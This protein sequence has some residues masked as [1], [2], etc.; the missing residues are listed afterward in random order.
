[1]K[2]A[3]FDCDGTLV[4]SAALIHETMRRTFEKFG[5]PEP[6]FEDTK[7]IIGLSLDI[8]IARM[9]G[10]P[11]VEQ[12]DIEMT[13]HYKSLFS[14]VRQDLDYKEPLF[15]GIREMI[16]AICG[17]EDLLVGAV[18]G[19]SRRGLDLVM[20]THGFDRH[21][22]V[23]RTA[24]DCPSKPHP[25]MVTECCD[26]TGMN[27]RDAIVIGDAIYDMQMAKAAGAK[28]IGVAWGYASVD[29]LIANGADAIAY[30]PNEILRHFS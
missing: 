22:T 9:Q 26:E 11:H 6:R 19:K 10:R 14:V 3:L 24:D 7:A 8:A 28:A 15:P 18:T 17:R 29:E 25:A 12:Q 13:A 21:F 30:H 27:A 5:K 16:D 4:D 2:L 1:M 20:E 23:A